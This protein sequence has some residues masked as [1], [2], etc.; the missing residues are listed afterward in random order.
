MAGAAAH[1]AAVAQS[2]ANSTASVAVAI[3]T[4]TA[5]VIVFDTNA[6]EQTLVL[7]NGRACY[8]FTSRGGGLKFVE[9]LRFPESV[10]AIRKKRLG[11]ESV[12]ALNYNVPVPVGTWKCALPSAS[13]GTVPSTPRQSAWAA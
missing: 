1:P 9:L 7:T 10:S 4:P 11:A 13:T 8:T 5:P 2:A 12:V 3:S 6:P